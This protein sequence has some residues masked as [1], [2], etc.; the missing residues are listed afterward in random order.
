MSTSEEDLPP[1]DNV[2]RLRVPPQSI[3]AEQGVLGALLLNAAAT[4]PRAR[5]TLATSDFFRY[6]HRLIFDAI[7][8]L[9]AAERPVDVITA[10]E[11]LQTSGNADAAGGLSYLNA[12]VQG[13]PS[14]ANLGRYVEIVHERASARAAIALLDELT[15]KAFHGDPVAPLLEEARTAI[16]NL[17]TARNAT[18]KGIPFLKLSQLRE[19][20]HAVSWLVKHV[21]PA[22]SV[23]MLYGA[24]GTFKSF[25]AL[26]AAL[27]VA[28]GLPW[29]GARTKPGPVIYIAAEGGAGLWSRIY[30]WHNARRLRITDDLPL[31]VVP[32]AL[33][34]RQ[35]ASLIVDR[36]RA[37][38]LEP[39]LVVVDT[40]SQTFG[41]EEN[42]AAEVSAYFREL[43]AR[44]RA[45]WRCC[46]AIVHHT[47]HTAT[48]RPRGS[49]AI[50]ANLD[51]AY[52][53]HRDENEML[54]TL[55]SA[56]MKDGERPRDATFSISKV[57]VGTDEDGDMQRSL[58]ARHLSSV[59]EIQEAMEL[60]KKAGRGG[61]DAL[62]LS[63]LQNGMQESDLRQ[64]FYRECGCDGAEARKKAWQRARQR[65]CDRGYAEFSGGY[66]I[67][68]KSGGAAQ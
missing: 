14:A 59:E 68:L 32:V 12:L 9:M 60:E 65:A 67:T 61:H 15:T 7:S 4:W 48:E 3:E 55:S 35:D 46:V 20:A 1:D 5:E 63:L 42:S 25:I 57:D 50:V 16:G 26:D 52:G 58:V 44:I 40:M 47:G 37:E 29:L 30:A 53:V 28:H 13:V 22:D 41:G 2:A 38:G 64:L 62:L 45:L 24:S 39:V 17:A 66:V 8:S 49:S 33:D 43:G 21:L 36:A 34:L 19:Q 56:K 18:T 11:Q 10:F 6:E 27:H 23:G 54:A 31:R 51:W